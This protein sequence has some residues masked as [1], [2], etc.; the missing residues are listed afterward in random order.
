MTTQER[1]RRVRPR[2]RMVQVEAVERPTPGCVR[3]TFAG[4]ELKDY[5]MRGPASHIKVYFPERGRDGDLLPQWSE[6][7][8][9]LADGERMPSSR[10]YTPRSYDAERNQLVV[11]FMLHGE[12]LASSWAATASVGDEVA[13]SLPGG[14]YSVEPADWYVIAGDE[15]ALPGIETILAE[16]P[17][18]SQAQVIVEVP[19]PAE[20]RSE[21]GP[22]VRWLERNGAAPGSVLEQAIREMEFPAGD[23]RVWVGC[24]AGAMREIRRHLLFDRSMAREAIHTHGYWK[25]GDTNHPDHDVG[26]E[27]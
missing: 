3:V 26:Q 4:D 11:E 7:G 21:L 15:A 19:G 16:L 14:P 5:A 22:D 1:P 9:I 10:T 12:G 23:G 27:I 25:A 20:V 18:A 6:E 13:V 17:D 2:P 24:E 8:P